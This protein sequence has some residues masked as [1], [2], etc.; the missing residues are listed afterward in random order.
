MHP[1]KLTRRLLLGGL[2]TV[3]GFHLTQ[4]T[5]AVGQVPAKSQPAAK[6]AALG[7]PAKVRIGKSGELLVP[8]GG[9]VEFKP[10]LP[11]GVTVS[12]TI[13]ANDQI[14]Q[15]RPSGDDPDAVLLVGVNSGVT[16]IT[17]A[18]SN[19]SRV[20]YEVVV[21]PDYE[22]LKKVISR[23]VPT[24]SVD[25]LPGVG[26][27][28]IL[29]GYVNKPSDADIIARITQGATGGTGTN[30]A[31][32]VIN[33]I[34]VGGPQHVMIE[35]VVAQV[36][37]SELRTRGADFFVNGNSGSFASLLSSLISTQTSGFAGISNATIS[38]DANL[39]IG[40]VSSQLFVALRALRSE[41]LSKILS[42]PK[43][44]T[45][46]GR[47]A[48][49]RSG[50]QQA[51]L[52]ATGGGLGSISVQLEQV[53]T[54]LEVLPIVYGDGKIYLE[55]SPSIRARN[56]GFGIQT[57][58]GFSPG[59]TEQSTRATVVLESG[60]TFAI[61]GLL[62]TSTQATNVK[63][64][65]IGDLPFIGTAFSRISHDERETE[66]IVL[67]TPRLVD[68]L[69]C[70]QVPR[71]L[72]G[73]ETRSPDDYE[74]FLEGLLEAPRGQRQ[75]WNGRCYNAAYKCDPTYG[76]FPAKGNI[77]NGGVGCNTATGVLTTG[78]GPTGCAPGGVPTTLPRTVSA[79]PK[80]TISAPVTLTPEAPVV[81]VGGTTL[82][83]PEVPAAGLAPTETIPTIGVTPLPDVAPAAAPVMVPPI[84]P[85]ST[86][87]LPPIDEKKP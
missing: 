33:A 18:L 48:V 86:T 12:G 31:N 60:Q 41:G 17:F 81:N 34:Q 80:P 39:R 22:L 16:R 10:K 29:T 71:R 50:G 11:A 1:F 78:C 84:L 65:F 47:P 76:T 30:S 72:P 36:N 19:N 53:G 67:V 5:P 62:E 23:A 73:R 32:S 56:D 21:Q 61:G 28:I 43:V 87:P 59:F 54:S 42:E 85:E 83:T 64:P 27:G 7:K 70:T 37:R 44:T 77:C 6:D 40:V 45:Q 26:S 20:E 55:V 14:L 57:S 82:P 2:A 15:T 51:V 8:L 35:V 38:P 79:N 58:A 46:S 4:G 25:V 13:V 69:D 9:L 75:V 49:I 3:A 68:A 52:S 66:L 24:A 74:L 63:V